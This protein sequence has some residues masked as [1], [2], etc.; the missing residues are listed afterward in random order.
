MARYFTLTLSMEPSPGDDGTIMRRIIRPRYSINARKNQTRAKG[1]PKPDHNICGCNYCFFG[2]SSRR[3]HARRCQRRKVRQNNPNLSCECLNHIGVRGAA[4]LVVALL[5]SSH[6]GQDRAKTR[7]GE[8]SECTP[9]NSH[10]Q[11]FFHLRC[12]GSLFRYG[13]ESSVSS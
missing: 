13:V 11:I 4:L 9:G 12:L 10:K 7:G 1:F 2:P 6:R 8:R 5:V 3:F